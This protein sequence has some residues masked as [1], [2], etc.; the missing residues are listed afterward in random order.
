MTELNIPLLRKMVE[1]VEE[2]AERT[3]GREWYQN[4]WV[5][6]PAA[7]GSTTAHFCDTA[8]CLAGKVA[9][10]AGWTPVFDSRLSITDTVALNG[11]RALVG[12]VAA[13]LL[14]LPVDCDNHQIGG[15][16]DPRNDAT[17]IREIAET[18]AGEPL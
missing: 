8:Y 2:Q 10:D 5:S 4:Q 12:E 1:W 6:H 7:L 3:E 13:E 17:R 15:L 9:V 14:G 16:F 11:E 18:I